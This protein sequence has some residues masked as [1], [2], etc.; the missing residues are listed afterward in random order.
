[1]KGPSKHSA[2]ARRRWALA[3]AALASTCAP[4][5]TEIV[6]RIDSDTC[7]GNSEAPLESVRV[8]LQRNSGEPLWQSDFRVDRFPLPGEIVLQPAD[9]SSTD[10][11]RVVVTGAFRPDAAG[12]AQDPLQRLFRVRFLPGERTLLSVFLAN[13][14]RNGAVRC[15]T[16]YTCGRARCENIDQASL[17][18]YV[19]ADPE[20]RSCVVDPPVPPMG[21]A[22]VDVVTEPDVPPPRDVP[23]V[24]TDVPTDAPLTCPAGR[25][26]CGAA[27][28][29][30]QTDTAHCGRCASPCG[31][32]RSCVLGVCD[33]RETGFGGPLGFGPADQCL[34]L[35]DDGSW[36]GPGTASKTTAMP[37]AMAAAFP[38]G[39]NFFGRRFED[40]YL[41]TNG[42]ITFR[43][44][45]REFAP[46]AFPL[47]GVPMLA[48]LWSDVD[49]RNGG[50]PGRNVICFGIDATRVAVTWHNVERYNQRSDQLNSFQ[51][52]LRRVAGGAQ[53]DW[54]AEFRYARCEWATWDP[55]NPDAGPVGGPARSGVNSGDTND[56]FS[57]P[58]SGDPSRIRDFCTGSN[59]GRP[60]VWVIRSRAG[61]LTP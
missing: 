10:P 38:R 61:R 1:M 9:E 7:A 54:D 3:L 8:E 4:G 26:R 6:L 57:L 53:D 40:F 28:V 41:N 5:A 50:N 14:C 37:I 45:L 36:N 32:G 42:N 20:L 34:G 56:A 15:R 17:P 59:V 55:P 30:V 2:A 47:A 19:S 12:V 18:G 13:R 51:L 25:V 16:G 43:A 39:I 23:V 31:A 58:G 35:S 29:D 11:V 33:A 22:G 46:R 24:P 49:T 44:P 48:P 52:V 60:G 27:C 21:D